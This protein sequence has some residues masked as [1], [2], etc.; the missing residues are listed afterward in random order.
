[1]DFSLTEE[2]AML[3]NTARDFCRS[4]C[5]I[6]LV[7]EVEEDEK[8]YSPQL[9]HK[10]AEL[11]WI[12]LLFPEDYGGLNLSFLELAIILEEMGR[13][14]LSGPFISTVLL[15]GF[16]IL[17]A[18][19][20]E[21]K[22][23]FLSHIANG[24]LIMTLALTEPSATYEASGIQTQAIPEGDDYSIS[25]TKLFV[26]DAH[27]ADWLLCAARTN[28]SAN[29]EDGITL[30]LV[31][32]KS[33]GIGY[34]LLRTMASDRQ[35]EVVFDKVKVPKRN[36]LGELGRGWGVIA[37]TFERATVA[38]CA[39]LLGIV[40][41][42]LEMTTD[43]AKQRVQFGQPIGS[44]QA[45]QHKCVNMLIDIE[46]VRAITYKVAWMLSKDLPCTKEV[47]MAKAWLSQA[48]RR[49]FAEGHQIHGG[50]GFT[51]DYDLQL[52]TR[53]AKGTTAL[54]GDD[55]FHRE[56]IAQQMGL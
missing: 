2:Q 35:C 21:Q 25:G 52:Y 20:E 7:R 50:I 49:V 13:V 14:V 37:E 30:F 3:K 44:F 34:T 48:S 22:G 55:D 45:I 33:P 36:I 31:N 23:E 24:D 38:H 19:T 56:I 51:K 26:S 41:S 28:D 12:G 43:Y 9:W 17:K 32:A 10:M 40:Q 5:P 18:G 15:G 1:M 42:I 54:F 29:K 46:G 8:G 53:R 11:G 39:F 4:E 6:K 47:S 16:P 27:I